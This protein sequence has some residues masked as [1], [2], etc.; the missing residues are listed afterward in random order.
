MLAPRSSPHALDSPKAQPRGCSR[1]ANPK[2]VWSFLG[3]ILTRIQNPLRSQA[4][5]APRSPNGAQKGQTVSMLASLRKSVT[6]SIRNTG[7][8]CAPKWS[9]A[10]R[11]VL[12]L[13]PADICIMVFFRAGVGFA[14]LKSL[15]LK[16]AA[17]KTGP[18]AES[19]TGHLLLCRTHGASNPAVS[20]ASLK[21]QQPCANGELVD[22]IH[23]ELLLGRLNLARVH[24]TQALGLV[25]LLDDGIA[26]APTKNRSTDRW[27]DI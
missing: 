20:A 4:G 19:T 22:D 17:R 8:G 13:L 11:A 10:L 27:I 26:S 5:R 9:M 14:W 3:A 23:Q 18:D 15:Q 2:H 24:A 12:P 1:Q 25:E 6:F 16:P 7:I 21:M